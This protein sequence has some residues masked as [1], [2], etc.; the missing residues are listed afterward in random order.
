MKAA[1]S[2]G[3]RQHAQTVT[4]RNASDARL[5]PSTPF[6]ILS[7]ALRHQALLHHWVQASFAAR[8][9][10][11]GGL[12]LEAHSLRVT[13]RGSSCR[14]ESEVAV[15]IL[16]PRSR[17]RCPTNSILHD[18]FP[19]GSVMWTRRRPPIAG[20][21]GLRPATITLVHSGRRGGLNGHAYDGCG[22]S[23]LKRCPCPRQ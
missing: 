5:P 16:R 22:R 7:N 6:T 3:I 21:A 20:D 17:A 10:A 13:S 2:R 11:R 1:T 4:E 18:R 9:Q 8:T 19:A 12:V 15:V 23:D 14:A